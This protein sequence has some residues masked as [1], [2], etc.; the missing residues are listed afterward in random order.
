MKPKKILFLILAIICCIAADCGK[1]NDKPTYYMPQDFKD[2]VMYPVGSYW[3]YEDSVSGDIDS[4]YLLSYETYIFETG[5]SSSFNYERLEQTF[6]SSYWLKQCL[7]ISMVEYNTNPLIYIYKGLLGYYFG[8]CNVGTNI[9]HGEYLAYSDSLKINNKWYK[10]VK[11]FSYTY[12][13]KF[14]KYYWSK[15]IGGIRKEEYTSSTDTIM[16]WNLKKYYINN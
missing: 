9:Q 5:H 14:S 4:I 8:D 16:V 11:C 6:Y 7:G 1:D 10:T 15:D 3:I 12:N 2:Y 13:Q